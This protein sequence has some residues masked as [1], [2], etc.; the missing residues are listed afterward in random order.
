MDEPSFRDGINI[1]VED[2]S[3]KWNE[4]LEFPA[5]YQMG[6]MRKFFNSINWYSIASIGSDLYV[7]YFFLKQLSKLISG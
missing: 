5:A 4:S 7:A 2:K 3:V 6:Y 1:T